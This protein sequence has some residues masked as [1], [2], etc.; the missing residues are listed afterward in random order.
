MSIVFPRMCSPWGSHDWLMLFGWCRV[1]L[2]EPDFIHA[3]SIHFT[4]LLRSYPDD[5]HCIRP[6]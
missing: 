2:S 5:F 1:T 3:P 4:D 6:G